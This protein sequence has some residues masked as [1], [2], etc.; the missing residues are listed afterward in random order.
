MPTEKTDRPSLHAETVTDDSPASEVSS[1][2]ATPT[3]DQQAQVAEA[4]AYFREFH[5][6]ASG[7]AV[8]TATDTRR[9]MP[10]TGRWFEGHPLRSCRGIMGAAEDH[11]EFL[12]SL[13]LS[14]VATA[15]QRGAD[16]YVCPYPMRAAGRKAGAA[17]VRRHVH[18]DI[19]GPIDL[20]RVHSLGASAVASGSSTGGRPHAH[21]YVRLSRD[22]TSEE[23][24][25]LCKAL[26]QHVGGPYADAGK[27]N[28]NDVLRVPGTLNHKTTPPRPVSWL[29]H[30]DDARTWEPEELAQ[31][32]GV[33]LA[34]DA[35]P[36]RNE[37]RT[38]SEPA[39]QQTPGADDA[40]HVARRVE[41]L[42]QS[43]RDAEEENGNNTLNWATRI[44][45]ALHARYGDEMVPEDKT[46]RAFVETYT[47]RERDP[48]KVESKRREGL[49]TVASGWRD[50]LANPAEVL[51][52][53]REPVP[54][55][56][57][58]ASS[59]PER[60]EG[61]S[62]AGDDDAEPEEVP[63]FA[64][65]AA[66]LS[67]ELRT[68]EPDAGPK[69]TDGTQRLYSGK[70]NSIFGDPE[71]AKSRFALVV[72]ADSLLSGGGAVFVDTDHNGPELV[73][74]FL[75]ELG[76]PEH[77]MIERLKYAE[78]DDKAE[79]LAVVDAVAA[80]DPCPVVF[81]SVGENLGLW[82]VS[83]NDD[84]GFLEMNRATAAR[85][86][87]CGHTVVTVDHLAKN[88]ES[89]GYGATGTAAKKRAVDGAM[90]EVRVRDEFS[91][92]E[93]GRSDMH[94]VKDR[95]GGV[96]A[97]G[98][99]RGAVTFTF[100]LSA[101]DRD[102]RQKWTLTPGTPEPT[103]EEKHAAKVSADVM[104]LD[105]LD[106]PPKSKNDVKARMSWGSDRAQVAW[107]EWRAVRQNG[108]AA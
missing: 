60:A 29:G 58:I 56:Q 88:A 93:G 98:V 32:L 92:A 42:I 17:T 76:V 51:D 95:S 107:K 27:I 82:G 77:V 75:A 2:L 48:R 38:V 6:S 62:T 55:V 22:V 16:V 64:D 78:P 20:D 28:D 7:G 80:M 86:A 24:R 69:L 81:D 49:G 73:L 59:A 40:Q 89:R 105:R 91:P 3:E 54:E 9:T 8:C 74:R 39:P 33:N 79:L 23:H 4:L 57:Q 36:E 21:V 44:A 50:G 12:E 35:E 31:K 26:G 103:A 11:A 25:T 19:D 53:D 47:A 84:Q 37:P 87:R 70:V 68:A 104:L 108:G 52:R 97:Q 102:G 72:Q 41:R 83:P 1:S 90:Y 46:R 100:H 61:F 101:P 94:L 43:V 15:T 34:A 30:P 66:I 96:R 5:G 99:K 10:E 18:A 13:A 14:A 63:V 67:G 65:L 106:P 45:G 85:L 71:S